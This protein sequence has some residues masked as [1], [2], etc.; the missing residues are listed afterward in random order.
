MI[1]RGQIEKAVK[2]TLVDK[3]TKQ[4]GHLWQI[5][6]SDKTKPSAYRASTFFVTYLSE[7]KFKAVFPSG[8][9]SEAEDAQVTVLAGELAPMNALIKLKGTMLK[10][11]LS[12]AEL[13]RY[14]QAAEAPAQV[15]KVEAA[16]AS[17]KAA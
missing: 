17:R 15:G 14:A 6:M 13:E 12:D 16:P 4:E 7:D 11:W 8:S 2:Q 1:L 9:A 5:V 3:V 10:G